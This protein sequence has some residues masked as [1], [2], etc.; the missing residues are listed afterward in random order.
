MKKV[1][2]AGVI[3]VIVVV[4]LVAIVLRHSRSTEETLN[5]GLATWVGFAPF[6]IAQEKGFLAEEGLKV[7]FSSM[8]D[9][10]ARRAALSSGALDSMV[11][12]LD[13]LANGL[14]A[15]LQAVCILKIDESYGADGIVVTK[16][17]SSFKDLKGKTIAYQHGL[18]PQF[19]LLYLLKQNGLTPSDIKSVDMEA[20]AAANAFIAR[21]VDAAVT[22]EPWLSKAAERDNAKVLITSKDA[23]GLITDIL[24]VRPDV[25]QKRPDAI[26]KLLRS[27][28]KALAFIDSAPN[29]AAQIMGKRLNVP[30][31]EVKGMLMGLRFASHKDNL[32]YFG[33]DGTDNKFDKL[34][35]EAIAVWVE[36]GS[37]KRSA[38]GRRFDA[39]SPQIL[40]SLD[41]E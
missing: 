31:E 29:E 18:P 39:S 12:T 10:A 38:M 1:P 28:F 36:E 23:P 5:V 4:A 7:S 30:P 35:Q 14:P 3:I 13:S 21:K 25:L 19:F 32:T 2:V 6:Y 26:R 40:K 11:D 9:L 16:D 22:W 27:W 15:G 17:I 33:L 37:V 8:D 24:V 41:V 20:S 34:M